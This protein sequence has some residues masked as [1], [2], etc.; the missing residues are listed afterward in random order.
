MSIMLN[1]AP[2][3]ETLVRQKARAQGR[4]A[5]SYVTELVLRDINSF[6]VPTVETPTRSLAESLEGLIGVLDSSQKNGGR[7]SHV[8]EN[9]GKEFA[10]MLVEKHEAGQ[11]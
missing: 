7:V 9:T 1:L 3:E 6:S 10:K 2:E 11:P 8:A 5:E 4:E